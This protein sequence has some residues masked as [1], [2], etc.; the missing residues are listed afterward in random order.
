MHNAPAMVQLSNNV[1]YYFVVKAELSAMI[2]AQARRFTRQLQHV[3]ATLQRTIDD[4][5]RTIRSL[6]Q[7]V[8]DKCDVIERQQMDLQQINVT[9]QQTTEIQGEA[10]DMLEQTIDGQNQTIVSLQ[11]TVDD[12][13]ETIEQQQMTLQQV[14]ASLQMLIDTQGMSSTGQDD[15]AAN[16]TTLLARFP[17][18]CVFAIT[19]LLSKIARFVFGVL[20]FF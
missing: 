6:Q 7:T 9:L 19:F 16:L 11:Q 10:I 12:K 18:E 2:G 15:I 13:C 4:Q 8:D 17:R 14:N 1:V 5:G 3:R 20:V